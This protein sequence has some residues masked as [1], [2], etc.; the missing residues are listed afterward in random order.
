MRGDRRQLTIM[1]LIRAPGS[2][3]S[4]NSAEI[5]PQAMAPRNSTRP[6]KKAAPRRRS[7]GHAQRNR[8]PAG[9]GR[10]W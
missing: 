6:A 1:A 3:V 10:R 2:V 7:L 5:M 4:L 8:S 9:T